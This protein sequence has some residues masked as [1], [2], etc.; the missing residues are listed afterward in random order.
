MIKVDLTKAK[1]I[2]HNIRRI[3][4]AEKMKPLDIEATIPAIAEQA[5][6][7]RQLVRDENAAIQTSINDSQ[8]EVE[9]KQIL[10]DNKLV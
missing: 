9:L 2:A 4:R 8:D 5:E 10:V 3:D 6:A 1:E 7:A